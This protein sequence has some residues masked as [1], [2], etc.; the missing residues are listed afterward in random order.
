MPPPPLRNF[1]CFF[2]VCSFFFSKINSYFNR[3][4]HFDYKGEK[5]KELYRL[6]TLEMEKWVDT[7]QFE[8]LAFSLS[9][10]LTGLCMLDVYPIKLYEFFLENG[11]L[12]SL[13][14]ICEGKID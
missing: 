13:L 12:A 8:G 5:V 1:A 10:G 11:R 6:L 7:E 14:D 9:K 2:V 3:L 4:A